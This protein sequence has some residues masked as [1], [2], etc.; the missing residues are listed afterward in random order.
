MSD[1]TRSF[2][3]G[4]ELGLLAGALM[5]VI[6]IAYAAIA[7]AGGDT[8]LRMAASIILGASALA[9]STTAFTLIVGVVVHLTL[10]AIYGASYG[11]YNSALTI[12]TRKSWNRQ[13]MLGALFGFALWLINFQ[14]FARAHYPWFLAG[15]QAPQVLIHCLG[16]GIP[17]AL[18]YTALERR[19][20][21]V[22]APLA[23]R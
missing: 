19:V 23:Y 22:Q 16:Y 21:P 14:V 6:E 17:L 7:G 2:R 3:E 9:G 8:P 11:I 20:R 5:A 13:A 12:E 4:I 10:A 1:T 18:A 15:H